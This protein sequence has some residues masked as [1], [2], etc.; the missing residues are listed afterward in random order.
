M[1][2]LSK[3]LKGYFALFRN[4]TDPAPA[5]RPKHSLVTSKVEQNPSSM[6]Q[7]FS[8]LHR[9]SGKKQDS[10]TETRPGGS[11]VRSSLPAA[12]AQ[13]SNAES[14]KPRDHGASRTRST[15]SIGGEVNLASML[16]QGH[17]P[18]VSEL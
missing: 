11:V 18:P 16:R 14:S 8:T 17:S 2:N 12:A 9:G 7:S 4:E 1:C 15:Q 10:G 5:K 6:R 3:R 13:G